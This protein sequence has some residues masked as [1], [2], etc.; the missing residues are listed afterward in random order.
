[1]MLILAFFNLSALL[2]IFIPVMICYFRISIVMANAAAVSMSYAADKAHGSSV[3]NFANVGFATL[4]CIA[5]WLRVS[6]KKIHQGVGKL[7]T[8]L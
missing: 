6:L 7:P 8:A 2:I 4:S 5:R 1:M 3:M